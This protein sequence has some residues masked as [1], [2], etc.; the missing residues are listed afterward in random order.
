VAR[1]VTA[2]S[3]DDAV[4]TVTGPGQIFELV[5]A[6]VRGVSMQVF[7]HAP[8][9]IGTLFANAR[10]FGD[11]TFLVYEDERLSFA[12]AADRIDGLAHALVHRYG[13]A[14]GD[15]VAIAMRNYPEWVM[16]FGAVVSVG[17]ISVSM[18]SWWTEPEMDYALRDSAPKV[19]VCDEQRHATAR[20]TCEALGI[21]VVLVRPSGPCHRGS[22]RGTTWSCRARPAPPWRW[23][24]TTTRPSSTPRAPR[25]SPREPSRR[26]AR[27]RAR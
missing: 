17:A 16:S 18:N 20:A 12:D 1:G 7:R 15:R 3:W 8:P 4:R 27:S 22:M 13:V 2:V 25:A 23:A 11:R 9:S 5:D 26:T 19:L 21:R 6:E 14:K 24:P 10:G